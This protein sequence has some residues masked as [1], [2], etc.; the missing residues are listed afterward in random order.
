MLVSA[1]AN[2]SER[3]V[4]ASLQRVAPVYHRMRQ[5]NTASHTNP[6]PYSAGYP[7]HRLHIDQNEKLIV[8]GVTHVAAIDG[9]SGMIVGF[10][11][12]SVKNPIVLYD[13]LYRFIFG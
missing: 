8:Y 1:G 13:K 12:M 5:Q 6:I 11:T 4:G 3:K 2:V 10:V 7:G 9:Y